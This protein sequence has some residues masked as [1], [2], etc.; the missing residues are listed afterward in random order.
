MVPTS[1]F[2][3]PVRVSQALKKRQN[4]EYLTPDGTIT[5]TCDEAVTFSIENGRLLSGSGVVSTNNGVI[6]QP[7]GPSPF[8]AQGT[9]STT[10]SLI[11][12]QLRW[13]NETFANGE[14]QYCLAASGIEVVFSA[15]FGPC[16]SVALY[17]I[18]ATICQ[19][20]SSQSLVPSSMSSPTFMTDPFTQPIPGSSTTSS[21]LVTEIG[22]VSV[23]SQ[24]SST[25]EST[26][27]STLTSAGN[28]VPGT[29]LLSSSIDSFQG[30]F[31]LVLA[32]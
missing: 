16:T 28:S 8:S 3:S 29:S 17:A 10:F 15:Q 5:N 26:P 32:L 21:P 18:P 24:L 14:A 31:Q 23:S 11:A 19:P 13:A 12:D 25:T 7:F 22:S 1:F 20:L 30:L 4:V 2:L 9:I 6:S 27:E